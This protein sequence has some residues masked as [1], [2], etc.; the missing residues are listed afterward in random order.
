MAWLSHTPLCLS[1]RLR[2][3]QKPSAAAIHMSTTTPTTGPTIN[4]MLVCPDEVVMTSCWDFDCTRF[5]PE[6]VV[7][8]DPVVDTEVV[9]FPH[10]PV[11]LMLCYQAPILQST[12]VTYESYT[13]AI[14]I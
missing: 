3:Y 7:S 5:V 14:I 9:D 2:Q 6:Q 12:N 11:L 10:A 13:D 8:L 4:P 1:R